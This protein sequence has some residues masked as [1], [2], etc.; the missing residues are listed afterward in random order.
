MAKLL[1]GAPAAK[2]LNESTRLRAEALRARGIVPTLAIVRTGDREDT[3]GYE[4]SAVKS[5]MKQGIEAKCV[6]LE[7]NMDAEKWLDEI[8]RLSRDETV[9]G[10]LV[11]FPIP[12]SVSRADLGRALDPKKDVDGITPASLAGAFTGSGEGYPPCTAD[13]CIRL[14]EYYGVEISGSRAVVIGRSLTV[15]RPAAMMLM[16]R[17]A[18]VTICHTRTKN[19]EKIAK[20]AD[21]LLVATGVK[22][23]VGAAAFKPGQTVVD[24]G[25]HEDAEGL[26]S[27]D[28]DFDS[29]FRVA[30]AITPV[31]GGVGPLTTAILLSHTVDAA[32]HTLT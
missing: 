5:C 15:G 18:T 29:A 21:I 2:A 28:A 24:V 13:A 14:L 9:H 17:N 1:K 30:D 12:A 8:R 7:E 16:D 19:V 25:F 4:R 27:G 26:F 11:L 20:E 23:S 22:G 32:D 6:R 31:P 10:V 3:A